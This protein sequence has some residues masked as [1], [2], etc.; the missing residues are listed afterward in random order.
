ML[1]QIAAMEIGNEIMPPWVMFPGED[2]S[3]R[4]GYQEAW[5][6][7]FWLSFWGLLLPCEREIYINK[8]KI[9]AYWRDCIKNYPK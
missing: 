7:E 3:W 9:P 2:V 1:S 6:H 4:Q 5:F 8:W